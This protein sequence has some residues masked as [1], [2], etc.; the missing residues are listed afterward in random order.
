VMGAPVG[1]GALRPWQPHEIAMR[2]LNNL[3]GSYE[4]RANLTAAIRAASMRLALP[5][6]P[7]LQT[8]LKAELRALQA[9]LN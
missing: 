5:A 9:R 2:M 1:H 6:E 4:R 7:A 8:T 3:V